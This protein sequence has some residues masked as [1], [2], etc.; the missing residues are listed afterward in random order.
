MAM[1]SPDQEDLGL[2]LKP[3]DPVKLDY[4]RDGKSASVTATAVSSRRILWT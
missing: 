4:E 2:G 3:G 1:G